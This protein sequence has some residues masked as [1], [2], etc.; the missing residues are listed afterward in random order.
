MMFDSIARHAVAFLMMCCGTAGV[1]GLL[2]AMNQM[3]E[4]PED[5]AGERQVAFDAPPKKKPPK[6]KKTVKEKPKTQPK[7][8]VNA[9]PPSPNLAGGLSSVSLGMPELD[10]TDMQDMTGSLLGEA[11]ATVMTEDSVDNK[12]RPM[13]RVAADYPARARSKGVEGYVRMSLLIN[14]YGQIERVKVLEASPRGQGFEEAAKQSV[15]QWSFEPATYEG[16]PVKIWA[17]QTV[18]FRLS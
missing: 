17:T 5:N 1:L 18:N 12:P 9:P 15:Q 7:R 16:E 11:K 3:S 13:Q 6:K 14:E 8:Q 4:G 2:V 10:T